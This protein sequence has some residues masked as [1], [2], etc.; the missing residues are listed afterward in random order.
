MN[1]KF[2]VYFLEIMLIFFLFFTLFAPNIIN[3]LT[4]SIIMIF[5]TIFTCLI[6]KRKHSTSIYEKQVT[7]LMFI[8]ALI[9]LGI[10]YLL[11]LYYGYVKSKYIFGIN[12]IANLLIPTILIIICSEI[13]RNKFLIENVMLNIK[14]KK[15]NL[16][17]VFV[18]ISMVLID[19][20][21]CSGIYD[22]TVFDDFLTAIGFVL[23]ASLSCNLL[24]NYMSRRFG[25]NGIIVFRIITTIYIYIFPI[26]PDVYLFLR[27]FFR[28]LYPFILYLI[29]EGTYS[30]S[31]FA[32]AHKD[33][34]KN[35][36]STSILLIVVVLMIMLISC[37]FRYGIVVIGSES[38]TG[39]LNKGD[40]VI[41]EKYNNQEIRK[42]Q[43]IIFDYG[44]IK[45]IHRVVSIRNVNNVVRYYTK[46][47]ANG[48]E[49][50]SYR[51]SSDIEGLVKLKIKYI[52]L[53]SLWIRSFFEK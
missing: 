52:G 41:Y 42:G 13:L 53:P 34:K 50:D 45:T 39:T 17:E 15:F 25:I 30:K 8:F 2:K 23:F 46:G 27:S 31:N 5:I 29:F 22:L 18:Y 14:N 1:N 35:I 10:F 40:A 43:V 9:Y 47:D 20:M 51:L 28:M 26:I 7:I 38:M 3:K 33:K 36:I 16:S 4:L 49:D 21:I 12:N 19:L 6:L 44:N 37:E 11:G 32:I 48:R 24:Y